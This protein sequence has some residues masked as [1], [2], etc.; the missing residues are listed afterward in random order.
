M[1]VK[2][3]CTQHH[4]TYQSSLLPP[5]QERHNLSNN[6]SNSQNAKFRLDKHGTTE[7]HRSQIAKYSE[8]VVRSSANAKYQNHETY[9][10]SQ[11]IKSYSTHDF[12][13]SQSKLNYKSNYFLE[14]QI[15]NKP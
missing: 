7:K 10:K 2:F 15:Y 14:H 6:N 9:P 3:S 8:K 5:R 1:R 11:Q 4:T 12:C 13:F